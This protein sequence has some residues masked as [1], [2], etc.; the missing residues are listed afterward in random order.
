MFDSSILVAQNRCIHT[1]LET[2]LS[3]GIFNGRCLA[4][5]DYNEVYRFVG[6]DSDSKAVSALLIEP[7]GKDYRVK[8][9]FTDSAYR[10]LGYAKQL[11]AI[12]RAILGT[13]Y[14]SDQQTD[15]GLKWSLAIDR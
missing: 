11:L 3:L 1:M 13:V 4:F 6:L 14:H 10:R 5:V 8:A 2:K 9:V 12:A 7:Y 15:M